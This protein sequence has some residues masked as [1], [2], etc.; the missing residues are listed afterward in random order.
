MRIHEIGDDVFGNT[1]D[2]L[3]AFLATEDVFAQLI[4]GLALLVHHVVVLEQVL[5]D[6]EVA[7]FDLGLGPFDGLGNHLVF[8]RL[9]VDHPTSDEAPHSLRAEDPHQVVLE[10]QE[11]AGGSG[12]ALAAGAPS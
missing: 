10:G 8:D 4:D 2:I 9:A 5:A 11:E 12:V 7:S 3:P 1:Q 6:L